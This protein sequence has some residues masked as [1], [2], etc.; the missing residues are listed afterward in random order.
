MRRVP[1]TLVR[2]GR[3]ER[4]AVNRVLRSGKLVQGEVTA[5]FEAEFAPLV[6]DRG[7]AAVNSGTSAL[8]LGLLAAGIGPG[9]EV[10][11]P[12]F[13]YAGTVNA[14]RLTGARPV[15]CDI[16]E[17]TFCVSP[18]SVRAAIGPATAAVVVVHLFGQPA[19]MDELVPVA[20]SAGIALVEDACQAHGAL[21][22]GRPVGSFGTFAAFSFYPTKNMTTCEGGMIASGDRALLERA[23][24]LRNQGAHRPYEHEVVGYNNRMTEMAAAIGRVQLR[25][26]P[27]RNARRRDLASAYS[28]ALTGVATPYVAPEVE[29]VFHQYTVRVPEGVSRDRLRD[30]L[31]TAGV[32]TGLYY[33]TP[34]H[35]LEPLRDAVDLPVTDAAASCVLSLPIHPD[36]R[37]RDIAYVAAQVDRLV[38]AAERD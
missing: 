12:S 2:L 3:A 32:G 9:D 38:A 31:R 14:V 7:C 4:R 28:A 35:R 24:L 34:C 5:A 37:G 13:T 36:L 20:E 22:R 8:H 33:P 19:N 25:A 18:E 15:Y 10:V 23:R 29:H 11:V 27:R 21:W 1:Q 17:R 26:L 16:D 6:G 30:D